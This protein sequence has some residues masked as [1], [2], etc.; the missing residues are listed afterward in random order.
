MRSGFFRGGKVHRYPRQALLERDVRTAGVRGGRASGPEILIVD[1]VLA[2]G[3]A[4]FQKKCL[5]KMGDVA[6]EGRTVLFVSHNMG[7]INDL[8]KKTILI[9]NGK[10]ASMG[11]TNLIVANYIGGFAS[12]NI[13]N[14]EKS[15]RRVSNDGLKITG[16]R[17]GK[18]QNEITDQIPFSSE[19]FI[20]SNLFC[21]KKTVEAS[22]FI[23]I[24]NA[25]GDYI[26][27][28]FQLDE[29]ETFDID[30]CQQ[31][32][33]ACTLPFSG[34][35]PGM[36]F[37]DLG[38]FDQSKHLIEWIENASAFTVFEDKIIKKRL[39]QIYI[40]GKWKISEAQKISWIEYLNILLSDFFLEF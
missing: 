32:K 28:P 33:I 6:T 37:V 36:Y 5:G 24:K 23:L 11:D 9:S 25:T 16:M 3:D 18:S 7:A 31:V 2:V 35:A 29:G 10:I 21:T 27:S 4:E 13:N 30:E 15:I 17:I 1:E 14:F 8:C 20:E 38:I 34:L 26:L 12:N 39:G 40:R 22:M 19:L